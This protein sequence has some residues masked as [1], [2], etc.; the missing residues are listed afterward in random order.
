MAEQDTKMKD[1]PSSAE[2][3][4]KEYCRR[5]DEYNGFF[6]EL[7]RAVMSSTTEAHDA[8]RKEILRIY[9]DDTLDAI[10]KQEMLNRIAE[11]EWNVFPDAASHV[12]IDSVS[13]EYSQ[14]TFDLFSEIQGD[15]AIARGIKVPHELVM[16]EEGAAAGKITSDIEEMKKE[17]EDVAK[18][19]IKTQEGFDDRI[20]QA[21]KNLIDLLKREIHPDCE[22]KYLE[23]YEDNKKKIEGL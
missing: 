1:I 18:R 15:G 21:E 23:L 22:K 4:F 17:V 16:S 14:C 2:T 6:E 13:S 12:H 10:S 19:E 9:G 5:R 20:A 3:L 7:T 8:F 11:H